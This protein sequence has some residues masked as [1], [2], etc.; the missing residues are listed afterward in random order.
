MI[1][2]SDPH[3]A[4]RTFPYVTIALLAINVL[5]FLYQF[6]LGELESFQFVYKF[7]VVPAELTGLPE[8]TK[9]PVQLDQRIMLLELASPIPTWATI[10]TSMFM[11]G[12]F[13]HIIGNMVFLWVFG[14]NVEDRLGHVRYLVFY[15]AAGV[16]AALAQVWVSQ[17]SYTPMVGASGAIAGV[18]GA[19][20]VLY[21]SSRV[22]TLIWFGIVTVIP[23]PAVVLIGI[24]AVLQLF[25]G[26]GSL[27]PETAGGGVAYFAH[28]G[29]FVVGIA[30]ALLVRLATLTQR[31]A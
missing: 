23:M 15:L 3:I 17:D 28:L 4:R 11:H 14:D 19:Y 6:T 1:P 21:P 31:R 8:L 25:S 29:G 2:L 20:L 16:A 30:V 26:L 9:V 7:G 24:W 27:G 12:G 5:V 13:L 22:N 10:F 18:L